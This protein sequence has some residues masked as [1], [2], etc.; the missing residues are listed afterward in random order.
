MNIAR[1]VLAVIV[2]LM[3]GYSLIM[4]ELWLAPYTLLAVGVLQLITGIVEMRLGRKG[5][6]A[7]SF[8]FGWLCFC[9]YYCHFSTSLT[10]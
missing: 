4:R 3:A 1:I 9:R 6:S 7:L 5:Y 10:R 8:A 2:V